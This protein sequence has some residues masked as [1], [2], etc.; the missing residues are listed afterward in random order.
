MGLGEMP[1]RQEAGNEAL[2][3]Y[4]M[5]HNTIAFQIERDNWMTPKVVKQLQNAIVVLYLEWSLRERKEH[6][7]VNYAMHRVIKHEMQPCPPAEKEFLQEMI[8]YVGSI[9][10]KEFAQ[11]QEDES[12]E[13]FI[14]ERVQWE[15]L[16]D[17]PCDEPDGV[18]YFY[19][20]LSAG[21]LPRDAVRVEDEDLAYA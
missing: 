9:T 7:F 15:M 13:V 6:G 16:F 8:D 18:V 12:K 14:F 2:P 20:R 19:R 21:L 10:I 4:E 11:A 17:K 1:E 5:T 3:V